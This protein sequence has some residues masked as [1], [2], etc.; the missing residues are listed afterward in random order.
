MEIHHIAKICHEANRAYCETIGDNSQSAWEEAENWQRESS[1]QGVEYALA[2]PDG[3]V[4]AQHDSW[5]E[6]KKKD[7]WVYGDIKDSS[8]K[9]H[10]C[11][12]PYDQLPHRQQ[13]KDRL[14]KAIVAAM[15]DKSL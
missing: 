4:S 1:I 11:M 2:N 6:A 15:S 3:P 14:F 5:L 7:G 8:K 10:P 9:E 13:L 12:V